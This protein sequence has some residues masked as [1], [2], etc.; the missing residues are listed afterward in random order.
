MRP[1]VSVPTSHMKMGMSGNVTSAINADPGSNHH[2]AASAA[3]VAMTVEA[4]AGRYPATYGP[5]PSM[6]SPSRVRH[7]ARSRWRG[8]ATARRASVRERRSATTSA[9]ARR[10]KRA[11]A[12]AMAARVTAMTERAKRCPA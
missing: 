3:G 12:H 5:T 11:S 9:P 4:R 2:T 6:P 7:D 8:S 1:A 10:P